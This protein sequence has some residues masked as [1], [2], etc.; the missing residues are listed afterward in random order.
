MRDCL[1]LG[2]SAA[3]LS[4]AIYLKRRGVDFVTIGKNVGGEMA[5]S[6]EIE[7]YPGI[8]Y[9]NGVELTKKFQ[10]HIKKY[11]IEIILVEVTELQKENGGFIIKGKDFEER[12]KAIIIATGSTPR[13]LNIPGEKEFQHKGVSQCTVCDGPLFKNKPVAIIGGGNSAN[14]AG[15]MMAKLSPKVYV[16]TKNEAMK[17][18]TVLI[19]ELKKQPNVEIITLAQTQEIFGDNFVRGLRYL[20]QKDNQVKTLA[21][22]GVFIHIGLT[23][24][25]E[26]VPA[27]W[28]IKNQFGE[29]VVDKLCQTALPG[30]FA[31][32]DVTDMPYKQIGVAVGQ[33]ITAAL[34]TINYLNRNA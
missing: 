19:Q 28:N 24:N 30:I 34:S 32:G 8:P 4:A 17:G 29:I 2:A 12:A 18:D 1:I 9:T 31:A 27:D 14:E 15:L 20:D 22:E 10:E 26:M 5:L 7:N 11:S 3:G 6:G 33:G 16:L 13:Q 23:P 21:V 25:S